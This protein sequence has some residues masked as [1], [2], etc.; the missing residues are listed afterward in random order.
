MILGSCYVD[1]GS[2][3]R[4]IGVM[5]RQTDGQLFSFIYRPA[6][7]PALCAGLSQQNNELIML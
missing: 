2:P 7:V 4:V 6:L 5:D 1:V 3:R